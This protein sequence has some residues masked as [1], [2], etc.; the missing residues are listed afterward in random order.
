MSCYNPLSLQCPK[1]H[2][3]IEKNGGCNHM[4]SQSL[5]THTA[6]MS[7]LASPF[8]QCFKCR[9]EFCW[10]CLGGEISCAFP[11]HLSFLILFLAPPQIGN[12]MAWSITSA[13]ATKTTLTSPPNQLMYRR[14][15]PFA[16]TSF[17]TSE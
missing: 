12:R 3:C 10:M 5:C 16:N 17:T 2:V 14:G 8:Q 7:S 9:F 11:Q 13:A 1:C 15:K 4:V 6:G